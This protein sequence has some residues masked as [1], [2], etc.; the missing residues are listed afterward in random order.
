MTAGA[1]RP[2]G[3]D[4]PG[5]CTTV[6]ARHCPL[7]GQPNGCAV[8]RAGTFDTPCW[9]AEVR[10]SP[11]ALASVPASERGRACLCASCATGGAR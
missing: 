5:P 10:M 6:A 3:D 4:A 9:C 1:S 2:G 8:A 7:C 11:A